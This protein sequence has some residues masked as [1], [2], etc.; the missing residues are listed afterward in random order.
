RR[1][2]TRRWPHPIKSTIKALA[3]ED[4][5]KLSL[6]ARDGQ[7]AKEGFAASNKS[8]LALRLARTHVLQLAAPKIT[9]AVVNVER[10]LKWSKS[11]RHK[12]DS[13]LGSMPKASSADL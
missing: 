10:I 3:V 1:V 8:A 11:L 2:Q 9:Y 7:A 5:N 13:L 12:S 4:K 6:P